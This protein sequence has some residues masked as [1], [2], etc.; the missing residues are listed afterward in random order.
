MSDDEM[1]FEDHL[2]N[3]DN[4]LLA[5][6]KNLNQNIEQM[7]MHLKYISYAALIWIILTIV[8]ILAAVI[9]LGSL[10]ETVVEAS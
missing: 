6:N 4:T 1:T 7:N 5:L 9:M 8:A 2:E 10:N 3:I